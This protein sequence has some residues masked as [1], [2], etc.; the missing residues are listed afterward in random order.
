M[1]ASITESWSRIEA[2]LAE[3]A[4]GTFAKLAPPA[5]PAAIVA[6]EEA[7]GLAF[8]DSLTESLLRHDGTGHAVVLPPFWMPL[9]THSIVEVWKMRTEIYAS[10]FADAQDGN[11]EAE[12]GPWWH[13]KWIP[14]A[15]NGGGDQLVIDQRPT[16][17]GGR[18]GDAFR[19]DGCRFQ[20]HAMWASLPTLLDMTATALETGQPLD[21]Y[22]RVVT[23]QRRLAWEW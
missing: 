12:Y 1:T 8:P 6:A 22:E 3:N 11:A 7:I 13:R 4:S 10:I 17:Y 16:R 14:F 20:P 5:E 2:W 19:E 9:S 23:D 18:I 21:G 15:G